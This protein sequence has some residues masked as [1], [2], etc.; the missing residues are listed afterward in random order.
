V[1][2]AEAALS[3]LAWFGEG[4]DFATDEFAALRTSNSSLASV[5]LF[6]GRPG[7]PRLEKS[8]TREL[9]LALA[10]SCVFVVVLVVP[11]CLV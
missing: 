2:A 4:L 9:L 8:V 1:V 7:R 6:L 5:A 3:V 11:W 10:S